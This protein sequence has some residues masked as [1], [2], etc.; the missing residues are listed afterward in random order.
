[1]WSLS[2]LAVSTLAL[3]QSFAAGL[4]LPSDETQYRQTNRSVNAQTQQELASVLKCN[5]TIIGPSDPGWAN[6]TERYMQN[7]QP[8]VQLSVRPSCEQ[9]VA[10]IVSIVPHFHHG[11]YLIA[12]QVRY[13][14]HHHIAFYAVSRGHSLT[15]DAARFTGIEIDMRNLN[16]IQ[17][18]PNRKTAEFQGGVYGQEAIENLW[19]KGLVTGKFHAGNDRGNDFYLI[20]NVLYSHRDVQLCKPHWSCPRRRTWVAT[21]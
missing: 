20:R 21:R 1:M 16:R 7:I 5:T 11:Y 12:S 13:A 19:G 18:K 3:V 10:R 8:R 4:V 9:D 15:T 14:N 6:A 2:I 17:V